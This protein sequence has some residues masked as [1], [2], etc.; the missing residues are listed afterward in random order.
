MTPEQ[1]LKITTMM[2][3]TCANGT[4]TGGTG[5]NNDDGTAQAALITGIVVGP[6][7]EPRWPLS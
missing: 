4:D 6:A 2:T 1:R 3:S 5:N 7:S